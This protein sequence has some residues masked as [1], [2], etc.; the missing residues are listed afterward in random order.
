MWVPGD[1]PSLSY[2]FCLL[3]RN[4]LFVGGTLT[5]AGLRVERRGQEREATSSVEC[6]TKKALERTNRSRSNTSYIGLV[7]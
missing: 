1:T 7:R 5:V 4:G 2:E 3:N 6:S